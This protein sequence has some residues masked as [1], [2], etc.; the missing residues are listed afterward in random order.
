[1]S[2][3]LINISLTL[4]GLLLIILFYLPMFRQLVKN[5]RQSVISIIFWV[6]TLALTTS[7]LDYVMFS[8]FKSN[9]VLN[10]VSTELEA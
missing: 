8:D 4:A 10:P 2:I 1:M 9:D 7:L 6:V 3:N 5:P